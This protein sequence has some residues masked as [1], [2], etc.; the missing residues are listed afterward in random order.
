MAISKSFL[1]GL[2]ATAVTATL[3]LTACGGAKDGASAS[4]GNTPNASIGV[5]SVAGSN[6]LGGSLLLTPDPGGTTAKGSLIQT[7]GSAV[8]LSGTYS[9][10][11]FNVS[12]GGYTIV[13]AAGTGGL[14]GTGIAPGG[15][16]ATISA[17]PAPTVTAP[18][19]ADPSGTYKGTF[20]IET[21]MQFKNTRADGTSIVNCTYTAV[22]VGTLTME[23]HNNGGGQVRAHLTVDS[24]DTYTPATCPWTQ[25]DTVSMW[26]GLDF[27]GPATSLQFGRVQA[28]P[29]GS[30]KK[31]WVTRVDAFSGAIS[32]NSIVGTAWRS[33]NFTTPVGTSGETH[34]EAFPMSGVIVTLTKQ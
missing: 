25:V 26:S 32:G 16:A 10:I 31:G 11:G 9:G 14:S 6:E 15:Q 27:Q 13:A 8:P 22:V 12:G 23:V 5:L 29:G 28:G 2:V 1:T 24:L 34:V 18:P 30:D 7:S 33:F 19:P 17:P 4:S 20:R 21:G 3:L